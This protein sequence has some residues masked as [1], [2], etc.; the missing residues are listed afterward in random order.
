MALSVSVPEPLRR[1]LQ[2]I[3]TLPEQTFQAL[4]SAL[5]TIPLEIRQ[6]RV[7]PDVTVPG[8][9]EGQTQAILQTVFG[10]VIGRAQPRVTVADA[11]EGLVDSVSRLIKDDQIETF[12]RRATEILSLEALDLITRANNVLLE[13]SCTYSNARI[14]SD[15]RAVFGDDVTRQ[16]EAAVIVHMLNIVY[17]S[18]GRRENMSVALDEKDIDNFIIVLERARSKN[19]TLKETIKKINLQ[20]IGVR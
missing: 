13:H 6:H 20:Y 12:R 1:G 4:M 10:M 19:N 15:I 17:Y 5:K 14:I 3:A 9:E 11:V 8:L 7:F 18:A 16:P 2:T